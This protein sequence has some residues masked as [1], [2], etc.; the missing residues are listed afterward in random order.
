MSKKIAVLKFG[1]DRGLEIA[2]KLSQYE[3][4][5]CMYSFLNDDMFSPRMVIVFEATTDDLSLMA[6][7][8]LKNLFVN[9]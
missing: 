1:K 3:S 4:Y 8:E 2:A 9:H 6:E 5:K 7:T